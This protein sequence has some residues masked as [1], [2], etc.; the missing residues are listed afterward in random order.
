MRDDIKY[1]RCLTY[2][3]YESVFT[4]IQLNYICKTIDGFLIK[5]E[6]MKVIIIALLCTSFANAKTIGNYIFLNYLLHFS[7]KA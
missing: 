2:S 7:V 6:K 5:V 3:I 4:C 1:L